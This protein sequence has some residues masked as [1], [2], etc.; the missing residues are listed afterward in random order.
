[1]IIT[2]SPLRVSI[3]GGATDLPSWYRRYGGI[4][5]SAAINKYVYTLVNRPFQEK[6]I[7]KYSVFEKVKNVD[8]VQNPI[9]RE[10]LRVFDFK[11]PQIEIMTC[12]DVPASTGL[13][14][15]SSLT[16]SLLKALSS[17]KNIHMSAEEI[18]NMAC[19]I[20]INKLN[21]NLGKQDQYAS[22]YGG[23][24]KFTFNN[25]DSVNVEKLNMKYD[26]IMELQDRMLLFF[27]GYFHNTNS[28]L[29]DQVTKTE[30]YDKD[31]ISNLMNVKNMAHDAIKLLESGDIDGYGELTHEHW[32]NKKKRSRGMSNE[33]IDLWYNSALESGAIG[34]K[35]V[36]SGDG[37]GFL[38]FIARDVTRLRNKMKS[39][40]L[41]ELRFDF[42]F[43]GTKRLA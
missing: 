39:F 6:L 32:I 28:A 16:C 8:E 20:E 17:Y 3:S 34:G 5:I 37:G 9:I 31:M 42:D 30:L 7:V 15:S 38:M 36:G 29:K 14:G 13:G 40:G 27:T 12:A 2:R 26:K 11:T 18:A 22:S 10:C 21:G 19:N 4:T 24:Q 35:L 43:E 1:M 23:L 41:E 33:N 25:D